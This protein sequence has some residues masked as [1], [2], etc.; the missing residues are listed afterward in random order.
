MKY[1]VLALV[2]LLASSCQVLADKIGAKAFLSL[3][4]RDL[5]NSTVYKG[6]RISFG[7]SI[8]DHFES[9]LVS[10]A[11]QYDG[12]KMRISSNGIFIVFGGIASLLT[13]DSSNGIITPYT[14]LPLIIQVFTNPTVKISIVPNT[15]ETTIGVKT[16]YYLLN[17]VARI[18]CEGEVGLRGRIDKVE[19]EANLGIPFTQGY[20][21]DKT[22]YFGARAFYFF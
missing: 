12:K 17:E 6:S 16:D 11:S 9:S 21:K 13:R 15:L 8:V 1:V 14:I 5:T 2:F 4:Y 20:F 3:D 19:V 18:Y 10:I 22:P 7:F